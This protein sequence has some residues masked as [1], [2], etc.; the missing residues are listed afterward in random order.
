M[1]PKHPAALLLETI[2][3]LPAFVA[4]LAAIAGILLLSEHVVSKHSCDLHV[5]NIRKE[6]LAELYSGKNPHDI[7][8]ISSKCRIKN[9]ET[10][11]PVVR[12]LISYEDFGTQKESCVV[13]P[14][15]E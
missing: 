3:I 11:G 5:E 12:I 1:K 6:I 15:H 8:I 4:L 7:R 14:S 2:A 9:V 10:A 13:W